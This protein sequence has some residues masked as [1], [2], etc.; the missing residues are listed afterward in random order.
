MNDSPA[1]TKDGLC[2]VCGGKRGSVR[3]EQEQDGTRLA[4]EV[5]L[6]H[7]ATDPF[8][9]T[10]CC[11]EW[12]GA[13]LAKPHEAT[14]AR[15]CCGCGTAF[16]PYRS[17]SSGP[18][19]RAC[20]REAVKK[21]PQVCAGCSGALAE[22]TIGC[23]TCWGRIRNR[24]HRERR[25]AAKSGVPLNLVEPLAGGSETAD[26]GLARGRTATTTTAQAA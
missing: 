26:G 16:S 14:P 18:L 12:H 13:P 3:N 6:A 8:C 25:A 7:L 10:K 24:E 23:K 20:V 11:R 15:T 1:P 4:R 2:V 17:L 19:C 22:R 21:P 9:S 5:W